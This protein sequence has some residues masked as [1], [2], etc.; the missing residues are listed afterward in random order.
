MAPSCQTSFM[1]VALLK[2]W[3]A[4]IPESQRR[5]AGHENTLRSKRRWLTIKGQRDLERWGRSS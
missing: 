3:E 5:I 1:L 2:I 4:L